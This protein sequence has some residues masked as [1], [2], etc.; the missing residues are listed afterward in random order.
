MRALFIAASIVATA[1]VG[2][3]VVAGPEI[4]V[5]DPAKLPPV[6]ECLDAHGNVVALIPNPLYEI[7]SD[8]DTAAGC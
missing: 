4:D 5:F 1:A 8:E 7:P 3:S 2:A 6:V